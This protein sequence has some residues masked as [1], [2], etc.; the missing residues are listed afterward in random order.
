MYPETQMLSVLNI[1]EICDVA[2]STAS[3]WITRKGLPAQRSGNKFWVSIED[4]I[5]FLESIGRPVPQILVEGIGGVYSYPFKSY[6]TCWNYWQKGEHGENC[7]NCE[8]LKYQISECFTLKDH[9]RKCSGSCSSCQYYYEHYTQYTSFIHQMSM[10]AAVL[11]DMY[12]WS[13]NQAWADLCGVDID[14]LIGMG[15]EEIIHPESIKIII[16]FN[17]KIQ[18]GDNTGFLKSDVFFEN[19]EGKKIKVNLAMASLKQPAG[20]YFAVVDNIF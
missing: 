16:N 3:Y 10:P 4:L 1:S 13:G 15:I 17:K 9:R 19:Q 14:S 20:A 12:I 8:V 11:K 6:Q 7:G 2:R 18:R 5:L